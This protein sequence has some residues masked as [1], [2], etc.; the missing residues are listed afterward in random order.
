MESNDPL[1]LN[2]TEFLIKM[3]TK[4]SVLPQLTSLEK[5]EVKIESVETSQ[6]IEERISSL[7]VKFNSLI[8][9][10]NQN[11]SITSNC[12]KNSEGKREIQL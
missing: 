11:P 9:V 5:E 1:K 7:E 3:A 4:K 10:L 12:P 8:E 2:N 6:N